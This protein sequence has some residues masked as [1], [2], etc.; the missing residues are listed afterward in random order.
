MPKLK[1]HSGAKKRFLRTAG[2]KFKHQRAGRRHLLAPSSGQHKQFMRTKN[3]LN[4]TEG[5]IIAKY[6]PYA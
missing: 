6:L 1:S 3:C 5:K 4:T 2:G